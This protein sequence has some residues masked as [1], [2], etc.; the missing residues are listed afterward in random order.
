MEYKLN[1]S[2]S[3]NSFHH[4]KLYEDYVKGCCGEDKCYSY[5]K[6]HEFAQYRDKEIKYHSRIDKIV[7]GSSFNDFSVH[8]K[9]PIS[10]LFYG[11]EFSPGR[12][13]YSTM[14]DK[15]IEP[16]YFIYACIKIQLKYPHQF[17]SF[18]DLDGSKVNYEELAKALLPKHL[19]KKCINSKRLMNGLKQRIYSICHELLLFRNDPYNNS[20]LF[21]LR[22]HIRE[23]ITKN[24]YELHIPYFDLKITK[25]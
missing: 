20:S 11:G 19:F 3:P 14:N 16:V 10:N 23:W 8:V 7:M 25:P 24:N 9:I 12:I 2:F 15:E 13:C 6:L 5:I 21:I 17:L 18:V 4:M 22:H 1:P